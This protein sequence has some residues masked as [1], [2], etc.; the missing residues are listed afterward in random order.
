MRVV[1][2][3]MRL[4]AMSKKCLRHPPEV[5]VNANVDRMQVAMKGDKRVLLVTGSK[6]IFHKTIEV[7]LE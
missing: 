5:G 1:Y 7:P 4:D 3:A 2:S 6:A